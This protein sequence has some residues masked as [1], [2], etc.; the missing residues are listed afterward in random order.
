MILFGVVI[1]WVTFIKTGIFLEN[2]DQKDVVQ[3]SQEGTQVNSRGT[4]LREEDQE[5]L[6]MIEG[7]LEIL[8]LKGNS[9]GQPATNV[10]NAVKSLSDLL[11]ANLFIVADVLEKMMIQVFQALLPILQVSVHPHILKKN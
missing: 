8:A 3:D 5:T 11:V 6:E 1:P 9:S 2:K 7:I 10:M 4:N